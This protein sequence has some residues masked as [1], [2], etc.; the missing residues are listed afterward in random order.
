M[1]E[2]Q[3]QMAVNHGIA[4][5]RMARARMA[6]L[7]PSFGA[8]AMSPG[9]DSKREAA[10]CEYGWKGQ[11]DFNDFF[12]LYS[13]GGI[14]A[15]AVNKL[16]GRCWGTHPELIEGEK[17]E[18]DR[19]PTSWE[20]GLKPILRQG[21]LWRAF[22]DADRRRLVGRYAALI[23]RVRDSRLME[24]PVQRGRGLQEVVV[25]WAGSI[26]PF[27][28]NIDAMSADYGKVRLWQYREPALPGQPARNVTIHSDRVFILGDWRADA[29]GFL[30]PV[31]NN[32]VNLEKTEGGSGESIAKNS[33]RSMNV[34]FD[35]SVDLRN[36]AAMYGVGINEL[37]EKF[38]DAARDINQGNDILFVTQGATVNPMVA[39]VPNPEPIYNVNLQSISAGVDIPSKILVGNQTGE[40]ASTEDEAY[41][42][43]RCQ[44][45]RVNEL[46][47][48]IHD[49]FSHLMTLR[50]IDQIPEFTVIWDELTEDSLGAKL[51]NAK[52]MSEVNAQATANGMGTEIFAREQILGTVGME[53]MVDQE[54]VLPEGGGED[55]EDDEDDPDAPGN[56]DPADA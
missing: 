43:R 17:K 20:E 7:N 34:N 19:K 26:V 13:R 50:I 30:E 40:R 38:N 47:F 56:E 1:A 55:D 23:L 32:F 48:E 39:N 37:Q 21:R 41:M 4:D 24:E 42:N 9:L 2:S 36:L 44:G 18:K 3:L 54:P 29:I 45:R 8:G 16:Y 10:W 28:Y 11:L 12:R 33:A 53:D 14:S 25:A 31:F 51:D 46:S 52:K 5:Y 22:A 35:G 6:L 49:F 15:G 27:E